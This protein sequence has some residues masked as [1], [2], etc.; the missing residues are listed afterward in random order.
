MI[1]VRTGDRPWFDDQCVL[2]QRVG[3]RAY[4]V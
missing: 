2:A 1:V 3:Q 4:R